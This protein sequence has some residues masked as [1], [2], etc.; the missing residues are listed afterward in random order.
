MFPLVSP[1][2]T[3]SLFQ[4]MCP[5]RLPFLLPSCFTIFHIVFVSTHVSSSFTIALTIL[6]HHFPP[7]FCFNTCV[8]VVYHCSYHLVSPVSTSVS[9]Y[10]PQFTIALTILFHH[11]PPLFQHIYLTIDLAILFHR[12]LGACH[13]YS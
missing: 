10:L 13:P 9:A 3:L 7:F 1:F 5:R 4:H 11:F 6:F 12:S 8:L 2:S